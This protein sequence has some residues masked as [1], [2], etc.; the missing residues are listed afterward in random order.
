[1]SDGDIQRKAGETAYCESKICVQ[2]P[3]NYIKSWTS[4]HVP[5][6]LMLRSGDRGNPGSLLVSQ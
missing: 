6:T 2:T 4:Q 1:M 5:V 3:D